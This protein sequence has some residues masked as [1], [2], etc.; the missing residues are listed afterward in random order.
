M[1]ESHGDK[2]KYV[3]KCK[4]DINFSSGQQHYFQIQFFE[5]CPGEKVISNSEDQQSLFVQER[6]RLPR[7]KYTQKSLLLSEILVSAVSKAEV[8]SQKVTSQQGSRVM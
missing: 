3:R 8:T 7:I 5:M 2:N 4:T 6:K 1:V